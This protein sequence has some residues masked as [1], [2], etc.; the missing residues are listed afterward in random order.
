MEKSMSGWCNRCG[1]PHDPVATCLGTV[2]NPVGAQF[3]KFTSSANGEDLHALSPE[4][5]A[6]LQGKVFWGPPCYCGAPPYP[7]LHAEGSDTNWTVPCD[8][9]PWPQDPDTEI[10]TGALAGAAVR[11]RRR[12]MTALLDGLARLAE[13][14]ARALFG[15]IR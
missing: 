9:L 14:M 7:H 15:W 8:P 2:H 5:R 12:V 13:G 10:R 6:A 4:A 3:A 11:R 1:S